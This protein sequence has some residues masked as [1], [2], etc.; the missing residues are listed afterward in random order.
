MIKKHFF[1]IHET[2]LKKTRKEE[3]KNFTKF[4]HM[5]RT[6]TILLEFAKVMLRLTLNCTNTNLNELSRTLTNYIIYTILIRISHV[7]SCLR[8]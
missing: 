6:R 3:K 7:A 8:I 1:V 2:S 4:V 5:I